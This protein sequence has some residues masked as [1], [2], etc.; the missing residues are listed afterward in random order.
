ML[1]YLDENWDAMTPF[2]LMYNIT[3]PLERHAE[4]AQAVRRHYIGENHKLMVNDPTTLWGLLAMKTDE[5]FSIVAEK[6]ARLQAAVTQNP[7]YS[8]YYDYRAAQS[9]S[10][11]LSKSKFDFGNTE[12]S[13][14]NL[15]NLVDENFGIYRKNVFT[16]V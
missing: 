3:Q 5:S 7:V 10:E 2:M 14:L 4:I 11:L 16:Q 12:P 1:T 6:S 15:K 8:Y 13:K 9:H